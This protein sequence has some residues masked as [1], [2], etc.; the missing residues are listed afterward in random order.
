MEADAVLDMNRAFYAA[1]E[2]RDLADAL[3]L[4]QVGTLV[5][6]GGGRGS[7]L[8]ELLRRWPGLRGTLLPV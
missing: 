8:V 6:V 5:D 3:D 2:A 1:H 7:L 4:R